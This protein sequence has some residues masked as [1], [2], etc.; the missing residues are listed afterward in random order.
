MDCGSLEFRAG[1]VNRDAGSQTSGGIR[2]N[3]SIACTR[4]FEHCQTLSTNFTLALYRISSIC[5]L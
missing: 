4:I 5:V 2:L 1:S 3:V